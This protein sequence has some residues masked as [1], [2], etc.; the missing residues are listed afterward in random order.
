MLGA[1]KGVLGGSGGGLLG[2]VLGAVFPPLKFL[3]MLPEIA[4]LA[5]G[6]L[7]GKNPLDMLKNLDPTGL[8]Q[9]LGG[10]AQ[11]RGL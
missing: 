10:A 11:Q 5:K 1:L 9:G 7:G 4:N 8:L 6:L 3:Q 2:G